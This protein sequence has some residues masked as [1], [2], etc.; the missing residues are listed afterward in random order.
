MGL[1]WE[2][3]ATQDHS[4]VEMKENWETYPQCTFCCLQG[5]PDVLEPRLG[6]LPNPLCLG[7]L[8][9][10]YLLANPRQKHFF[11]VQ[12]RAPKSLCTFQSVPLSHCHSS[13]SGMKA[14]TLTIA[15]LEVGR[16]GRE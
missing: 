13:L 15:L 8:P 11:C 9:T 3:W 1:L 4:N 5:F 14:L 2:G 7:L 12:R 10:T 16:Q 6:R